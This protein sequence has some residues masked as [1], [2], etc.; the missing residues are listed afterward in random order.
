MAE[1]KNMVKPYQIR[2]SRTGEGGDV[3][4]EAVVLKSDQAHSYFAELYPI[5]PAIE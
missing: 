3:G 5:N 4:E 1:L 2:T